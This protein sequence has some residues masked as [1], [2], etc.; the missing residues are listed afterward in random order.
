M[1]RLASYWRTRLLQGRNAPSRRRESWRTLVY[2][3]LLW[4]RTLTYQQILVA[5]EKVHVCFVGTLLYS[6]W[7]TSLRRLAHRRTSRR[8]FAR[9]GALSLH[10]KTGISRCKLSLRRRNPLALKIRLDQ[11]K[12]VCLWR[13][14]VH[15]VVLVLLV[16]ELL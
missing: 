10:V 5:L 4:W 1:K 7:R 14:C 3:V 16:F 13:Y 2:L 9:W 11:M 8:L 12:L 15:F 6:R